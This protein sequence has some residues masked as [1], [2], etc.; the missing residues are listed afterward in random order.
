MLQL[1]TDG[2]GVT[3]VLLDRPAVRNALDEQLIAR[4]TDTFEAVARDAGTRVVVMS[5]AG[6]AF[7]A[8]ADLA[9]MRRMSANDQAANEQD[10]KRLGNLFH[11]VRN[12]PQPVLAKVH[13]A[14]YA[15]GIG[16][17]AAAD[18]A[19]ASEETAFAVSEVKLG[20]VPANIMP[21]LVEA[22]GPRA[23]RRF[24]LSGERFEAAEARRLGLVHEVVPMAEIDAK[25]EQIVTELLAAGPRAQRICKRLIDRVAGPLSAELQDE[26]AVGLAEA[27]G[28]EEARDRL[29]AFFQE[30][31]RA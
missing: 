24:A 17:L 25:V 9:Y 19:V 14:A 13:G 29:A 22:M 30:R 5:G 28:T 20:L 3:S 4:L 16:L 10:A 11:L 2:R 7:C 21:Y 1:S 31:A 15:G 27:R 18:I 8:G 6:K 26:I 23:V 12:C